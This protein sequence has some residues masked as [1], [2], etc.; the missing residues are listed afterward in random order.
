MKILNAVY[1]FASLRCIKLIGRAK[2]RKANFDEYSSC[3]LKVGNLNNKY[4]R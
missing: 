3:I 1:Y 2:W 4:I